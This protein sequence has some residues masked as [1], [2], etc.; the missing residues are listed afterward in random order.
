M[1]VIIYIICMAF[2]MFLTVIGFK[3]VEFAVI[4][5]IAN[6]FIIG[7]LVTGGLNSAIGYVDSEIITNTYD[8]DF[9]IVFNVLFSAVG[10]FKVVDYLRG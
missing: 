9:A 1:D 6:I 8:I 10:F 3:Y 7:L 5:I 2:V 4:S